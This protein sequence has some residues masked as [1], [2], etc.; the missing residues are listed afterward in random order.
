M[1]AFRTAVAVVLAASACVTLADEATPAM[2][3]VA[4]YQRSIDAI[5]RD[6]GALDHRLSEHF[7]SM[8]LAYRAN[9][10]MDAAI[11]A[12]R[13]ALHV[14]RINKGLHHL[15]HVPVV[16][17]LID[18]YVQQGD[19]QAVD[20]QQRFRYWIHKRE[21]ATNSDEY[22]RSA[23]TYA[24]W[25][26][27][28]HNLDTGTPTFTKL[29][30]ALEALEAAFTAV[31]ANGD[32]SDP[33]LVQILNADAQARLNLATYVS[34]T[35]ENFATGGQRVDEDLAEI[36]ERR[37][38]IIE[39]FIRG[40]QALERVA[41]L[42]AAQGRDI[43]HALALAN[44]ADWELAFE[45]PQSAREN[46]R[47][48]YDKLKAA[49]LSQ[50]DIEREFGSPRAMKTFSVVRRPPQKIDDEPSPNAFVTATFRV[51][52]SGRVRAIEVIAANPPDN[53][54]IVR[55]A[56]S[57]LSNTRFR[58]SIGDDG[59]FEDTAT[60]RYVFPDVSI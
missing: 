14:N 29:R 38:V 8:G 15:V 11:D 5:E 12:F 4:P 21:V 17:L 46:Y 57:T 22:V 30:E 23:M 9:G 26:S 53:A 59:P 20:R 50:T 18:T 2:V 27:R 54:R 35:D 24:A 58:P 51:T 45:R 16:D 36:I 37:N 6:G 41:V 47:R 1:P 39:S 31:T 34:Y 25:Q 7:L 33:R 55:E 10:D 48:A 49:G 3:D 32:E 52:K 40:K 28:A 44:L 13:Q 56:R 42:T 19:W 43:E 60:I